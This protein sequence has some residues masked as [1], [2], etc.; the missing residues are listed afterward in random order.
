MKGVGKSGGDIGANIL[1]R[2][3]NGQPT[4]K[5]LWDP[6]TGKFPCGATVS[7]INDGTKRCS[8][9]TRAPERQPQRLPLPRRLRRLSQPGGP[10]PS[11]AGP[12][13]RGPR[14]GPR[15]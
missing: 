14:R 6:T 2:Y 11:G 7:G 3:E 8:N 15:R 1:Y 5:P 13:G 9:I 4:T 10:A 12:A